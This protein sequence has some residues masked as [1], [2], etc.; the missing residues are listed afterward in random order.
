[1][2]SHPFISIGT[3]FYLEKE[4]YPVLYLEKSSMSTSY[5]MIWSLF[6]TQENQ[7]KI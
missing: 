6:F 4:E 2:C 3:I 7:R 5:G 1:M